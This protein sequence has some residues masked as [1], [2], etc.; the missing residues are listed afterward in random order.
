MLILLAE[1]IHDPIDEAKS[2]KTK[3][4]VVAFGHGATARRPK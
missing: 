1:R 2:L 4:F 3:R